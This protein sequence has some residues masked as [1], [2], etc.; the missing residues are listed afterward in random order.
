MRVLLMQGARS[1]GLE[2]YFRGRANWSTQ[3]PSFP[4][5]LPGHHLPQSPL[6]FLLTRKLA[7][8]AS[9]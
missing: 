1:D 8:T 2:T 4:L 9:P 5:E 3:A 7:A 6:T